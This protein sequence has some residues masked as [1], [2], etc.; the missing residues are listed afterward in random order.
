LE[1]PSYCEGGVEDGGFVDSGIVGTVGSSGG[2]TGEGVGLVGGISLVA[3]GAGAVAGISLVMGAVFCSVVVG[4][5][6]SCSDRLH[7]FKPSRASAKPNVRIRSDF[8]VTFLSLLK[9]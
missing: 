5:V 4:E 2:T 8:I 3:T 7:P 1:E 9:I 6:V